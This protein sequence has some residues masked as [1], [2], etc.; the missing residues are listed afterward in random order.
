M[1][2][3]STTVASLLSLFSFS[4]VIVKICGF[5]GK[6]RLGGAWLQQGE[7]KEPRGCLELLQMSRRLCC[8]GCTTFYEL[9]CRD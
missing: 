1:K 4:S 2:A 9:A 8:L 6:F 5:R 7:R 3:H